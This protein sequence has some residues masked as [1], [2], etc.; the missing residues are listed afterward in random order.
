MVKTGS[1]NPT[2]LAR[3]L[4]QLN[5]IDP[6]NPYFEHKHLQA[7]A[8]LDAKFILRNSLVLDVTLNPDFSQVGINNP[9]TPEP[10]LP[11][12]LS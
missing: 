6:N 2:Y 7:Y 4:R 11:S 12:I 1:L 3:N 9:A 10:T 5:V 8:G